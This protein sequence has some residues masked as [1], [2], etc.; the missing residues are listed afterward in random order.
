MHMWSTASDATV[1]TQ[2]STAHRGLIDTR[3]SYIRTEIR[4]IV[5]SH[6]SKGKIRATNQL[7]SRFQVENMHQKC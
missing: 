3:A 1:L 5:I 4:P 6:T 7:P 2:K